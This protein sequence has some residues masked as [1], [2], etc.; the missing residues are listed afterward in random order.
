MPPMGARAGTYSKEDIEAYK[1]TFGTPGALTAA[2][3]YYR[4]S[5]RWNPPKPVSFRPLDFPI[6]VIFGTGDQA[7]SS[8]TALLSGQFA[9]G[10]F[11]LKYVEGASHWLHEEVPELVNETIEKF[12][13]DN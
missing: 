12:L 3:N 10:T 4:N 13:R 6:L 11:E 8:E 1:Y 2:I 9:A 5:F 7:I